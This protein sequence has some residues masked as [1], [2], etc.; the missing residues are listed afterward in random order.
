M[1][2]SGGIGKIAIWLIRALVDAG[3]SRFAPAEGAFY[4]YVDISS[5]DPRQAPISAAGF[6]AETGVALTQVLIST[7]S[8]AAAGS[9]FRSPARPRRWPRPPAAWRIGSLD[10]HVRVV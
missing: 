1:L 4:L 7:R 2:T 10:D 6:V 5:S 3:L 9:G 8:T